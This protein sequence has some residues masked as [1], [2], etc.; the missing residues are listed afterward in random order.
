MA[1]PIAD[2]PGGGEE[3]KRTSGLAS[4]GAEQFSVSDAIGGPRGVAESVLPTLL[5]VI[6]YTI[7]HD[8]KPALIL[9]VG[10]AVLAMVARL[11]AGSSVQQAV[12]GVIGVGIC[13]LFAMRSGEAKDFYLPG[14]AINAGYGTVCLLSLIPLPAMT[15][16]GRRLRAGPYPVLGL[17]LGPLLG[18]GLSWRDHPPRRRLFA[19][20]TLGWAVFFL[21]KVAVQV[22]LYLLNQ[23]EAL[24]VAKI[25]MGV[26]AFAFMCYVTWLALRR[27]PAPSERA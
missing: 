14:F 13:A 21:L 10:A 15:V 3:P 7:T 23:V 11:V 5:F 6:T 18:E 17:F 27:N 2:E 12:S 1:E 4:V 24:G 19:G 9:A 16:A 22:P 20:L 8:L 26:P 25:A